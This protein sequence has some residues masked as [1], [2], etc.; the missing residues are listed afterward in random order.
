V[1]SAARERIIPALGMLLVGVGSLSNQWI[2]A[3]LF[4]PDGVIDDRADLTLIW[5]FQAVTLAWGLINI[6]GRRK[7]F[8]A[9]ANL[10]LVTLCLLSPLAGEVAFRAMI[11]L[12]A[13]GLRDPGLYADPFTDDDYWKLE[14]LWSQK[15]DKEAGR[16]PRHETLGWA[17]PETDENPLGL[18]SDT[19]YEPVFE[20]K[21]VLFFGNSFVAGAT[22]MDEKIPQQLETLLVDCPVHNFGVPGFGVD[23]IYLRFKQSHVP[24]HQPV[25]LIG[26][27]TNNLDRSILTFRGAPKP[28][29]VENGESLELRGLPLTSKPE[30][31]IAAHPLGIR[32]F[33]LAF[34]RTRVRLHQP[35]GW[36][37]ISYGQAKKKSIN[38]KILDLMVQHTNE[39]NLSALFVLF[40]DPEEFDSEGWR[41]TFL[42]QQFRRHHVDYV[43]TKPFLIESAQRESCDI[44]EYYRADHHL[45]GRGNRIVAEAIAARLEMRGDCRLKKQKQEGP[46]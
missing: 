2:L 6:V 4:S 35:G 29:F 17:P 16:F 25:V 30:E 46:N 20:R 5:G 14:N 36:R 10:M 12:G 1:R 23:Q 9:R 43:D 7:V 33:L 22:E 42:K 31:W 41:E 11:S 44:G 8:I 32:S 45:N 37:D 26:I 40:Y 13:E 38:S 21:T 24:F 19:P 28:Y 27:L 18:I 34:G 39:S 3:Y 15:P